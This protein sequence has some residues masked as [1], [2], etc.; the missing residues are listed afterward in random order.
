MANEIDAPEAV[1]RLHEDGGPRGAGATGATGPV[2]LGEDAADDI[3]IDLDP[4]RASDLPGDAHAAEAWV[5]VLL[6]RDDGGD[7]LRRGAIGD[8]LGEARRSRREGGS[9]ASAPTRP[10]G[11]EAS[12][13][14]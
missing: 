13:P 11:C 1:L 2:T 8:G 9:S 12:Y 10:C 4:H 14:A 3:L 7:K 6:E 5:V